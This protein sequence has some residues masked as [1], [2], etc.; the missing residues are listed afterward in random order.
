[1]YFNYFNLN[2][3]NFIDSKKYDNYF[4][5]FIIDMVL[6]YLYK[7]VTQT[8]ENIFRIMFFQYITT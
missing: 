7:P 4:I 2:N 1:M 5:N 3:F 8:Y 6:C